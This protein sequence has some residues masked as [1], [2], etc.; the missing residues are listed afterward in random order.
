MNDDRF[1]W[2][3]GEVHWDAGEPAD[4]VRLREALEEFQKEYLENRATCAIQGHRVEIVKFNGGDPW[5]VCDACG[6]KIRDATE[7]DLR[8]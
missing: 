6:E 8:T 4:P 1:T 5:V 3:E 7:G 2:H